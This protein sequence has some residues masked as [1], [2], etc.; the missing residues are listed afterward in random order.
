MNYFYTILFS[1]VLS[2]GIT[3][4]YAE[5]PDTLDTPEKVEQPFN[6]KFLKISAK[7][8]CR[9]R[10]VKSKKVFSQTEG[11][12]DYNRDDKTDNV[13][14]TVTISNRN[15]VDAPPHTLLVEIF[16]KS[17][18]AKKPLPEL[19]KDFTI[20][21]P[22]VAARKKFIKA[23]EV[24]MLYDKSDDYYEENTHNGGSNTSSKNIFTTPAFGQF[25]YG[26][27]ITL[28]NE[29]KEVVNTLLWP[30][31]LKKA[32]AKKSKESKESKENKLKKEKENTKK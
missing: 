4:L 11:G 31:S 17:A 2:T 32:L 26:Y 25:F 28:L 10:K 18:A 22:D 30:S 12:I 9:V 15:N 1:I 27:K 13:K 14:I 21:I 8:L 7:K 23:F 3:T 6:P 19:F 16:G 5:T 29:K 20:D 24:K